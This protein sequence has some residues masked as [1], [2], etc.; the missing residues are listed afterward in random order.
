MLELPES[1]SISKQINQTLKGKLIKNA[2]A[3]S[4][5]HK[6]A[7]YFGDPSNYRFL[8]TGQSIKE[9]KAVAGQVELYAGD[10]RIL[11]SDGVNIRYFEKRD[12][13]PAKHQLRID[14]EDD[15]S[16]VCCVQ[17]YG[18][19]WVYHEGENENPYYLVAKRKPSPL[20]TDFSKSY[21]DTMFQE[22]NKKNLSAKAFLAT[23]QRI[24][25]LGNGILQDIL[26]HAKIHPKRK[27]D[28][29]AR[30]ETN[31]LFDAV[32]TVINRMAKDGGRDT[33]KDLF[34]KNG[35][36]HTILSK[37]TAGKPCPVCGTLIKKE[38]YLGGS[39]YLC[40]GCQ[41]LS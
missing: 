19:L 25:G 22:E 20:S 37:N 24:P 17:M 1:Y 26:F 15:S 29:L 18:G 36:Y 39:I 27:I 33:E 21:F 16:L 6:F 12:K 40:E 35:G 7:W 41:R 38:A 13:I 2:V 14:F 4:S 8:L 11:F 28:T 32:K 9:A 34:G 3:N 30:D 10:I 23:E 5:P 31:G